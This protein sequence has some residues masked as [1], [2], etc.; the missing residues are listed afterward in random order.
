VLQLFP[1]REAAPTREPIVIRSF[2]AAQIDAS[3]I[4]RNMIGRRKLPI[5]GTTRNTMCRPCFASKNGRSLCAAPGRAPLG[6]RPA[7][8]RFPPCRNSSCCSCR[9]R[10]PRDLAIRTS[11]RRNGYLSIDFADLIVNHN[12]PSL[13]A[14]S[15]SCV[16][17]LLA[18]GTAW[19]LNMPVWNIIHRVDFAD[20]LEGSRLATELSSI[21]VQWR[22]AGT[23]CGR[24][25]V[26]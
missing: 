23:A 24:P 22:V 15:W 20:L 17:H 26:P 8:L 18:P 7:P 19:R 25:V 3:R 9:L 1:V 10:P 12:R 4:A 13:P 11:W 5:S 6:F 16:R 2:T 14:D 21:E